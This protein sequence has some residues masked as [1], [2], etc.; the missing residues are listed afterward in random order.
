[1]NKGQKHTKQCQ[2]IVDKDRQVEEFEERDK[3]K[4]LVRRELIVEK[5][6]C[7]HFIPDEYEICDYCLDSKYRNELGISS[8]DSCNDP[9]GMVPL[10]DRENVLKALRK[11]EQNK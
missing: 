10:Y 2:T 4:F 11:A 3:H 6:I 8:F 1:M 5:E 7:G 9:Y